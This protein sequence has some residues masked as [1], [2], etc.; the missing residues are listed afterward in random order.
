MDNK[1]TVNYK[2][3][4]NRRIYDSTNKQY[5]TLNDIKEKIQEGCFVS[6]T[7]K[8]NKKDITSHVL[9]QILLL[10]T[11]NFFSTEL[12][13]LLIQLPPFFVR[14][15]LEE[16]LKTNIQTLIRLMDEL[17][18]QY[19]TWMDFGFFIDDEKIREMSL[20]FTKQFYRNFVK[21]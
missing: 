21:Q 1:Q 10:E 3:Y 12:L 11:E 8:E 15:H 2:K 20:E 6:V 17:K 19:G 16:F 7:D 18:E 9:A 5:V 14:D 4:S 13:H